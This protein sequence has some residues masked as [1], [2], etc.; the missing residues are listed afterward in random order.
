MHVCMVSQ[1]GAVEP[2]LMLEYLPL[3][4]PLHVVLSD[5]WPEE[6]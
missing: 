4:S 3:H 2:V 6:M 5:R 1:G